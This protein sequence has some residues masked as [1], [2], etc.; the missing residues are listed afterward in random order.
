MA[1]RTIEE[2]EFSQK[3][4]LLRVDFNVPIQA[5]KITDETRLR[6][7]LPT[8]R[9]LLERGA[10]LIII[11][12]LGRPTEA[13]EAKFSLRQLR[14]RLTQLSGAAVAFCEQTIGPKAEAAAKTLKSGEILLLENTRYYGKLET[15]NDPDFAAK[16]A[17]LAEIYVND[18][19]GSAHRAHASTEGVAHYLPSCAGFLMAKECQ[20]FSWVL[21]S[22]EHPCVAVIGGAKVS[23]KI[24]VLENLLEVCDT[25][26]IGGGMSYTFSDV[27]GHSIGTSLFEADYTQTARS[28]LDKAKAK[29]V[30]VVLPI[31]YQ[32]AAEFDQNAEA[33]WIDGPDI[34]EHLMGMDIGPKTV[35]LFENTLRDAKMVIWNGPV[36]V[37]EWKQFAEGTAL[38]AKMVAKLNA[39]TIIGGGDSVAAVNQFG[40][41]EQMTHVST[42]GG[43]SLEY[44]EGKQL[45]GVKILE[46][47]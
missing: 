25:F 19:F 47:Q 21:D 41:A 45:P 8:I 34:P 15:K 29:G 1:I 10:A 4:V 42:G 30:K 7:A 11:S 35:A 36:G 32:A 22:P 14:E 44:L 31:D 27:L 16:L 18:A 20:F 40:L 3:R 46:A 2:L 13:R 12:H 28:F 17:A 39:T 43:A 23:S 33:H 37:F 5:G 24:S 6:A 38:I 26:I 9:Y